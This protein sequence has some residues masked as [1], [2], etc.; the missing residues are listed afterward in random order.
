VSTFRGVLNK[1]NRPLIHDDVNSE[2]LLLI[3]I[4]LRKL[5]L[6][7]AEITEL[8]LEDEVKG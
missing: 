4:Q 6:H 3:L 7:L 5:N 1:D 8:K 2:L